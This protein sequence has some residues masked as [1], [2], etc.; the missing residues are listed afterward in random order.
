MKRRLNLA[1]AL[2]H[3][4]RL[5]VLDE[6]TV[7]VDPQSRNSIL[8]G[9][10][11]LTADGRAILYATHYMEEAERLCGRALIID[12]GRV[13]ADAP[14]EQLA[15]SSPRASKLSIRLDI[16]NATPW[17][18]RLRSIAG[19]LSAESEGPRLDLVLADLRIVSRVLDD[20]DE[21]GARVT[22]LATSRQGLQET[23]LD[24]TGREGRDR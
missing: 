1:V 15:G 11:A 17:L 24:L 12:R 23:F 19:V 10:D 13:L 9:L 22:D 21:T 14:I 5:I 2:L 4:P 18:G 3:D 8:D 16:E 20:L 6:P 7:G